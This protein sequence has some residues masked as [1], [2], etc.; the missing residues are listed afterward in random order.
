M[1]S[2]RFVEPDLNLTKGVHWRPKKAGPEPAA[3][4]ARRKAP[5]GYVW[6]EKLQ[7]DT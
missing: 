2:L 1:E 5:R 4:R 3:A 7:F 6:K